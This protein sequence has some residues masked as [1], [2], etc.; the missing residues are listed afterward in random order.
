MGTNPKRHHFLPEF[1]LNGFSRDGYV[2]L[3]DRE[4]S[5]FRRQSAHDTAV[6]RY[7]YAFENEKGERDFS[8]ESFLSGVEGKA[9]SIIVQLEAGGEI[10]PHDRLDLAQFIALLMVRTPKFHSE[11]DQIADASSKHLIKHMISTVEEAANLVHKYGNKT[12]QCEITAES[13]FKFIH[14]EEFKVEMTRD[15][16]IVQSVTSARGLNKNHC[17]PRWSVGLSLYE[18][19]HQ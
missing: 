5:Q 6:I 16:V 12:G 4:R 13:M 1:Y 3:Y 14:N 11:V 2:W 18:D 7:Y 15:F 17:V 9:K 8:V 10:K 19:D